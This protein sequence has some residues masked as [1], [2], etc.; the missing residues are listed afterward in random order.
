MKAPRAAARPRTSARTPSSLMPPM[1]PRVRFRLLAAVIDARRDAA[2]A[3]G[4][5]HDH[6]DLV[7]PAQ[8]PQLVED[9]AAAAGLLA[10]Q[11]RD[12]LVVHEHDDPQQLP[13]ARRVCLER[14]LALVHARALARLSA[15]AA[16]L[17]AAGQVERE[18]LA[19]VNR[20][21]ARLD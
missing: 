15:D 4:A 17:A 5:V 2:V 10:L 3:L 14:Q 6:R 21:L 8:R 20:D 16:C 19:A 1:R 9:D 18:R 13:A 7:A 11:G 12:A